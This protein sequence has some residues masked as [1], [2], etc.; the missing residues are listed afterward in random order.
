MQTVGCIRL[1]KA[2]MLWCLPRGWKRSWAGS[3]SNQQ[4]GHP[5][6]PIQ[7]HLSSWNGDVVKIAN[8]DPARLNGHRPSK[9]AHAPQRRPLHG[10]QA[11]AA[12]VLAVGLRNWDGGA[13]WNTS[14]HRIPASSWKC[15]SSWQLQVVFDMHCAGAGAEVVGMHA[16]PRCCT[17]GT[18]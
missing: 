12:A 10:R 2:Q 4:G 3:G 9:D 13:L 6:N 15:S 8:P 18:A 14:P 5:A 1:R 11:V 16:D 7:P 17:V